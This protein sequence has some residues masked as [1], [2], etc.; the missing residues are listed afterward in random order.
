MPPENGDF[1]SEELRKTFINFLTGSGSTIEELHEAARKAREEGDRRE[2]ARL[3][4]EP[5][6]A[7]RGDEYAR[8]VAEIRRLIVD[9]NELNDESANHYTEA[10]YEAHV[11][12]CRRAGQSLHAMGGEQLMKETIEVYVPQ[13]DALHGWFYRMF[14]GIGTWQHV[15]RVERIK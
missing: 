9:Y 8:L 14:D 5:D 3:N 2:V 10:R 1:A 11:N 15:T 13:K 12:A 4:A 7:N 6:P